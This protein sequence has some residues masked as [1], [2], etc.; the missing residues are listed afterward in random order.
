MTLAWPV[1]ADGGIIL[2]KVV[3]G[4]DTLSRRVMLY[5]DFARAIFLGA[6]KTLGKRSRYSA[7]SLTY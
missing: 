1:I 6:N 4:K 5:R 7:A 3:M 2:S